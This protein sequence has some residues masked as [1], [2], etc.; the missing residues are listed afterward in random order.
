MKLTPA[1]FLEI[2]LPCNITLIPVGK[3]VKVD[4]GS[5]GITGLT[6]LP[7]LDNSKHIK[8]TEGKSPKIATRNLDDVILTITHADYVWANTVSYEVGCNCY[9]NPNNAIHDCIV[10]GVLNQLTLI[11]PYSSRRVNCV[12]DVMVLFDEFF[13]TGL[14]LETVMVDE[15][16]YE[17]DPSNQGIYICEEAQPM[18]ETN[19]LIHTSNILRPVSMN[20]YSTT[21][22]VITDNPFNVGDYVV[23]IGDRIIGVTV[24]STIE[25]CPACGGPLVETEIGKVRCINDE[26]PSVLQAILEAISDQTRL[27]ITTIMNASMAGE[28]VTYSGCDVDTMEFQTFGVDMFKLLMDVVGPDKLADVIM[29]LYPPKNVKVNDAHIH[30][31]VDTFYKFISTKEQNDGVKAFFKPLKSKPKVMLLG[32]IPDEVE[33]ALSLGLSKIGIEQTAVV[34]DVSFIIQGDLLDK[35]N[36]DA[37]FMGFIKDAT[38][39]YSYK[40]TDPKLLLNQLKKL[41]DIHYLSD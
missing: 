39:V 23:V 3:R 22:S 5:K 34:E 26:C 30:Y 36:I 2:P 15:E 20:A 7:D 40:L 29:Y 18:V 11:S 4:M 33:F 16:V 12:Q 32:Y 25:D 41:R 10:K 24:P 27:D 17:V 9:A 14:I 38:N 19:G 37:E 6:P 35:D 21:R 1:K 31:L 13:E 28:K 8:I